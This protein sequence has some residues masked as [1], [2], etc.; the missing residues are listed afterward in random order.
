MSTLDEIRDACAKL[1]ATS[2]EKECSHEYNALLTK[3][4]DLGGS[5]NDI[6]VKIGES[7]FD[8]VHKGGANDRTTQGPLDHSQ[9]HP[10]EG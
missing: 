2:H 4:I 3:F 10:L 8:F 7:T 9:H 5:A 6:I 1:I